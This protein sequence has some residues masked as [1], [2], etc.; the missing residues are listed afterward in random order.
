MRIEKDRRIPLTGLWFATLLLPTL[1]SLLAGAADLTNIAVA[2]TNPVVS[3]GT[4][5]PFFVATGTFTDATAGALSNA[6]LAAGGNHSC[7]IAADGAVR[8]WGRNASGQLGNG[9]TSDQP[10]P[11]M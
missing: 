1:L 2:P 10:F 8:C 5:Q 3:I 11:S 6:T 7:A 9:S 4:I